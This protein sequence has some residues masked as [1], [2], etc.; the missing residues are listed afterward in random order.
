M[1]LDSVRGTDSTGIAVV[2]RTG[3]V[4][5]AKSVGNPFELFNTK[6]YDTS[7]LGWNKVIIGH[8]RYGTQGKISKKNAHPFEFDTLVGAHNGTLKN[9]YQLIDPSL[10]DV[11]SEN[12]FHHIEKKGIDDALKVMDGAWALVWWDKE[13]NTLNFLRN[14][15]RPLFI[16]KNE[17][18]MLY[19]ASEK[20][21][22]EVALPRH[23]VKLGDIIEIPVDMLMSYPIKNDGT[24]EKV[25]I[26]KAESKYVP[27]FTTRQAGGRG[28]TTP[29]YTR[30]INGKSVWVPVGPHTPA[31]NSNNVKTWP[32]QGKKVLHLTSSD[33][34]VGSKQVLLEVLG[35]C[36]DPYGAEFYPLLDV[37]NPAKSVR[38]YHKKG[39]KYFEIGTQL[40]GDISSFVT[41]KGLV[42]Y[43]KVSY[44]SVRLAHPKLLSTVPQEDTQEEEDTNLLIPDK[45]GVLIDHEEFI[46]RYGECA[47]CTGFVNPEQHFRFVYD[48][49]AAMCHACLEDDEIGKYVRLA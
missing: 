27:S 22:L 21:M 8:N 44:S 7:L 35:R 9:K 5:M 49:D 11:D 25:I 39:E 1:I 23:G 37:N 34:Y 15:E 33:S 31:A 4:K 13:A 36:N 20:W 45:K 2:S 48:S 29:G 32:Q 19:W 38:L 6:A 17:A 18:G 30:I 42:N 43:Y 24:V 14:K 3:E 40:K 46:Q 28:G 10:F 26:R 12:L 47:L 41:D 16:M